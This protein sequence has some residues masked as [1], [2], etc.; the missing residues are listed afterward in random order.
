MA[1][2]QTVIYK[3][4]ICGAEF[5]EESAL[6]KESVPCY[7]EGSYMTST[8]LDMCEECSKKL[9][10]VIHDNFAEII[11]CYGVTVKKKF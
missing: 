9:R 7:G 8:K 6:R 2:I 1:T 10:A 3:C 5:K 11:D 4:D